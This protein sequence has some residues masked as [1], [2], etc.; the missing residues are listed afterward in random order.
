MKPKLSIEENIN[1]T[2]PTYKTTLVKNSIQ[3]Q[4]HATKIVQKLEYNLEDR[5]R[6]QFLAMNHLL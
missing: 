6:I 1:N 4:N 3:K 5:K 2:K